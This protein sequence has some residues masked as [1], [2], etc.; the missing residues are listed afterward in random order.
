M[1]KTVHIYIVY[2]LDDWPRNP[3]NNFKF[4]NCCLGATNIVKNSNKEK[5]VY[6]RYGITFGSAGSWCFNKVN[7]RIVGI[8]VVDNSSSS[9]AE[10]CKN[11]FLILN[12]GPTFGMN[13]SFFSPEKLFT[14]NFSKSN[15]KTFLSL[16][17]NSDK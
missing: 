4:K 1:N 15:T 6:S 9:Y 2:D 8:F 10:N 12:E 5:Y 3:S 11:N 7:A 17:Y 14:I 16:H 13:E